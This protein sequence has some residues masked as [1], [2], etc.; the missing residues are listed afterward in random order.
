MINVDVRFDLKLNIVLQKNTY[1]EITSKVPSMAMYKYSNTNYEG[2]II[3]TETFEFESM[4]DCMI[5]FDKTI[6]EYIEGNDCTTTYLY[7]KFGQD[8]YM[9]NSISL[10]KVGFEILNMK[11]MLNDYQY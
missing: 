7:E 2:N 10:R 8:M 5:K 4:A 1:D 11:G 9:N 6:T 3:F